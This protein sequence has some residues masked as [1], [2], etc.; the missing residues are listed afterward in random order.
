VGAA[1]QQ[2]SGL[3][4]QQPQVALGQVFVQADNA[5]AP[6]ARIRSHVQ[7]KR[8][9]SLMTQDM[10]YRVLDALLDLVVVFV[11]AAHGSIPFGRSL[12]VSHRKASR[13]PLLRVLACPAT[14][15]KIE[16]GDVTDAR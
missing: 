5:Q 3:G 9:R 7:A 2:P 1:V 12:R 15:V 16:A 13:Q 8:D 10:F 14:L 11:L 6:V 4:Q